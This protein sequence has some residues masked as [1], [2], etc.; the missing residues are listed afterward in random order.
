M[1]A[2]GWVGGVLHAKNV[3][4]TS[5]RS[6]SNEAM[7]FASRE[8]R[9]GALAEP[10]PRKVA[11]VVREDLAIWQKLNVTAFLSS[12]FGSQHPEL[13]G[14]PYRDGSD[15]EYLPMFA[16]PVVVLAA[17]HASIARAFARARGRDLSIS[18]YTDDLFKTNND[19]DNRA[20]V[21]AVPTDSLHLAG[22]AVA[23]DRRQVDKAL[24]KLRLHP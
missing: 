21:R 2:G 5:R 13:I 24:D 18:V 10:R 3:Q 8:T 11:I 17:D 20:A 9:A 15:V 6:A 14:Q 23:G 22:F 16:Q 12:G 19:V 7:N 1:R 4:D